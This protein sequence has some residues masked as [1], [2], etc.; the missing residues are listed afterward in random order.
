VSF[1]MTLL[2][3]NDDHAFYEY[4]FILFTS[5][6]NGRRSYT[7]VAIFLDMTKA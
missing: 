7:N 3:L 5:I 1:M 4:L 6:L 2:C